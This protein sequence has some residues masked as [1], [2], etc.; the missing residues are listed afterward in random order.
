MSRERGNE[1]ER[2][3]G[4]NGAEREERELKIDLRDWGQKR[5]GRRKNERGWGKGPHV[6]GCLSC[7]IDYHANTD[8]KT[9]MHMR[10]DCVP[11][12]RTGGMMSLNALYPDCGASSGVD[13]GEPWFSVTP[14]GGGLWKQRS[15]TWIRAIVRPDH[16]PVEISVILCWI[17]Q[18]EEA[19]KWPNCTRLNNDAFCV[20][21]KINHLRDN[22]GENIIMS[23]K[24]SRTFTS[25][26]AFWCI[27]VNAPI[28]WTSLCFC[29]HQ[30]LF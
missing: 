1:G 28:L 15:R 27:C 6:R 5:H 29:L 9:G 22:R 25:S 12:R 19:W 3:G 20:Q 4:G 2:E 8:L 10:R 24:P 23:A 14:Q 16:W 7:L 17:H 21:S 13:T 11:V 30:N 18:R 26:P